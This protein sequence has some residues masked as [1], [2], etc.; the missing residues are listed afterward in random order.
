MEAGAW[1][2]LTVWCETMVLIPESTEFWGNWPYES[3]SESLSTVQ[4]F[5][6]PWTRNSL[7]Q[8][9][10]VGSLSLLQGIF[11]TQGLNPDLPHCRW[12][13][14]QLSHQGSPRILQWVAYP[15]S[16][17][18]TPPRNWTRV[19]Y[20]ASRFFTSWATREALAI[21]PILLY[22]LCWNMTMRI[23]HRSKDMKMFGVPSFIFW[24]FCLVLHSK[25]CLVMWYMPIW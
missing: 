18:S 11:S 3:E 6:T 1:E 25:P 17:G 14:Y 21:W 16:R 5:A 8:N 13:L 7:S 2:R 15:F 22:S 10:G 20:I 24:I 12:I 9:T 23:W 4:L 19:S